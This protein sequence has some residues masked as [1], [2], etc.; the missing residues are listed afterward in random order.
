MDLQEVGWR[1]LG[2]DGSGSGKEQLTG[3][4]ECGNESWGSI[5]CWEF[6]Q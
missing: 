3:S 2:L 5:K 6:L 4:C 1:G